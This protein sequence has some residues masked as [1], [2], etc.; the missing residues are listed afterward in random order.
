MPKTK[1]TIHNLKSKTGGISKKDFP[2]VLWKGDAAI[3][4]ME[5][6]EDETNTIRKA[7]KKK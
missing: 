6:G 4:S 1:F 5:I 2:I 3:E 7:K